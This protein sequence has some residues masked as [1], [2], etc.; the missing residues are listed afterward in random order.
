[1]MWLLGRAWTFFQEN[2]WYLHCVC[3]HFAKIKVLLIK[4]T[5]HKR[6]GV[7]NHRPINCLFNSMFSPTLMEHQSSRV[8]GPMWGKSVVDGFPSLRT[9]NA[10]SCSVP[11]MIHL[12][13]QYWFALL[14][15]DIVYIPHAAENLFYGDFNIH[16]YVKNGYDW[17]ICRHQW[18]D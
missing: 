1:M 14:H 9:S 3:T 10:E 6:H 7:S 8:T 13:I 15:D 5:S 16:P 4:M 18:W 17:Q 2:M 11:A 12:V